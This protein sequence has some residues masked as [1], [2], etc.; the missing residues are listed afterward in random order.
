M[1]LRFFD[2]LP[3]Y[4]GGKRRL[5]GH[6]F[7]HLPPAS[8]APVFADAFLGGGSVSLYAKGRG[9]QVRCNDIAERSVVIG[10]AL[11][12][13]DEVTLTDPDLL[14][15]FT[16]IDHDGFCAGRLAPDVVVEHH[17]AFLDQLMAHAKATPGTKG[18]LLR[19][20]AI[21][22]LFALRP[23]GNFGAKTIVHQLADGDFD[24]IKP[25][26]LRC[27]AASLS[28]SHPLEVV[29]QV[30][31]AINRGVFSNGLA[32]E[33]HHGDV[34]DF[35]SGIDA[36]I[37]YCDFPYPGTL[38]YGVALRPLDEMLAG[39]ALQP[40]RSRFSRDDALGFID[41][42]LARATHIPT[43]AISLGGPVVELD[44]LAEVVGRY[45]RNVHAEA[46]AYAHLASL[47][48]EDNAARNRELLVI[49]TGG[50]P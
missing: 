32:H 41:E 6:I 25:H 10:R 22:V 24:G 44:A 5:V 11:V 28:L 48:T 3:P 36:D 38:D 29:R 37:L 16:D 39:H 8:E 27:P 46:I 17:A 49:G 33:V 7:K 45:R 12:D 13:N 21:K 14:R 18:W 47:A 1:S 15:L 4:F 30:A 9:Y 35:V 31:P 34:L 2:A 50:P 40:E 26:F 42:T 43:W 19:L 20:A 23:M